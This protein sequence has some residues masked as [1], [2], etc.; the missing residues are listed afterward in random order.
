MKKALLIILIA[1]FYSSGYSQSDITVNEL[2][3]H[4]VFLTSEKNAGRYP[5]GKANKRIV[6]YLQKDL[7]T[8]LLHDN[9][10]VQ[11]TNTT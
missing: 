9:I 11:T 7:T 1:L 4:I 5:G 6:K 2:K 10:Q 8:L 3:D